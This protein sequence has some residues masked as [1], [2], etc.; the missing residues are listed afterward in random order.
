MAVKKKKKT[1]PAKR[2]AA[3]VSGIQTAALTGARITARLLPIAVVSALVFFGF[4]RIREALYSDPALEVR[5]I[6]IIPAGFLPET[7]KKELDQKWLGTNIF[8][9]DVRKVSAFL[10][11]DPAVLKAD[12][13]KKFPSTLQVQI[14]PRR[15][16][17][18]VSFVKGGQAAVISEDGVILNLLDSKS[19]FEGPLL[20]AFESK[21]KV[22]VKGKH[23]APKGLDQ[24]VAFYHQFQYHPLAAS[25]KITQMSLNYLGNL[26]ITLGAGPEVKLGNKPVELLSLFHKLDPIL[27]PAERSKI[28]YIDLQFEDVIVKKRTR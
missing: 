28:Q 5:Q 16:F 18:R 4:T 11:K 10:T 21:L 1:S 17:A 23:L 25:E 27:D 14:T 19:Q 26:S 12:T 8:S 24:A 9:A 6:Q 13:V 3:W 22:P 20:E 2:K 7:L 15:P